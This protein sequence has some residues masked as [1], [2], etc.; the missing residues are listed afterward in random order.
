MLS[1]SLPTSRV[2]SNSGEPTRPARH[3]GRSRRTSSP[4]RIGLVG[5]PRFGIEEPLAG[6]MEAMLRSLAAGLAERGSRGRRVRRDGAG[7]AYV[8]IRSGLPVRAGRRPDRSARPRRARADVSMPPDRF[9]EEHHAFMV[10]GRH[11]A[12]GRS[13]RDPQP[14]PALPASALR[15]PRPDPPHPAQPTD[16]RGWSPPTRRRRRDRD[17]VVSVSRANARSW[18]FVDE[19]VYNGVEVPPSTATDVGEP[20]RLDGPH[21]P[22]EGHPPRHRGRRPCGRSIV[23]AGPVHDRSYFAAEVAPRLGTDARYVGHLGRTELATLVAGAAAAVVTPRWEE[24]FGLVV[25]EALAVG[26]PVAAFATGRPARAADTGDRSAGDPR[27]TPMRWPERSRRRSIL[28]RDGCRRHVARHFS[29]TS[30]VDRYEAIYRDMVDGR[31]PIAADRER[32]SPGTCTTTVR[33]TPTRAVAFAA[34]AP[35]PV[36]LVSELDLSDRSGTTPSDCPRTPL[37]SVPAR[38]SLP[39]PTANGWL[40]WAPIWPRRSPLAAVGAGRRAPP[41]RPRSVSSRTSRWRPGCSPVCAVCPSSPCT[42]SACVTT[43]PTISAGRAQ[44]GCSRRTRQALADPSVD[45]GHPAVF[46]SGF[47]PVPHRLRAR[48]RPRGRSSPA[49]AWAPD[50]RSSWRSAVAATA[51]TSV[52]VERLTAVRSRRAGRGR[53]SDGRRRRAAVTAGRAQSTGGCRDISDHLVAADVVV[54]SAGASDRRRGGGARGGRSC[55]CPRSG[56]SPSRQERA[57]RLDR[58]R[59]RAGRCRAGRTAG[60]WRSRSTRRCLGEDG[61]RWDRI[62]PGPG[63]AVA[64][65]LDRRRPRRC[66]GGVSMSGPGSPPGRRRLRRRCGHRHPQR[67]A[68]PPPPSPRRGRRP[69]RPGTSG[70]GGRRDGHPL[71]S[72]SPRSR[73]TSGNRA[74]SLGRCACV[75]GRT[76]PSRR[77]ARNAGAARDLAART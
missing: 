64:I 59:R 21:R 1:F 27:T 54:A 52:D 6:G 10:L 24:P 29:V 49:R 65:E 16:R 58:G 22:G 32:R 35:L 51:P 55:A 56:P 31:T 45:P 62:D 63:P 74:R 36:T 57:R 28:D 73:T 60:R 37:L 4:L 14:L 68:G 38:A 12:G 2:R 72:P 67:R 77:S 47:V 61:D 8:A 26:T 50:R 5:G 66:P 11:L 30:M 19:V 40:H 70:V 69:L 75:R 39:D 9:M 7:P 34:A 23:L 20:R 43:R 42:R 17:R 48:Y 71:A 41:A 44:P 33:A 25:A 46:H 3:L 18:G 53:G 76:A 13:R 15:D